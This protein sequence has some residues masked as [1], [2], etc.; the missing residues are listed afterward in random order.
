MS[1]IKFFLSEIR[2]KVFKNK[3]KFTYDELVNEL[4]HHSSGSIPSRAKL[5]QLFSDGDN[6]IDI[7]VKL[8]QNPCLAKYIG[9]S[10]FNKFEK[11]F[12]K[13]N[14]LKTNLNGTWVAYRLTHN[15]ELN[16]SIWKFEFN[17]KTNSLIV[18]K[19]SVDGEFEGEFNIDRY[20]QLSG[21]FVSPTKIVMV[22]STFLTSEDLEAIT[23]NVSYKKNNRIFY[24]HEVMYKQ[25]EKK[26]ELE[27]DVYK[28]IK[29][30]KLYKDKLDIGDYIAFD[31][32]TKLSG[33]SRPVVNE[34][35]NLYDHTLFIS[36]PVRSFNAAEEAEFNIIKNI[37]VQIK[38]K[39]LELFD[40]EEVHCEILEIEFNKSKKLVRNIYEESWNHLNSS[41]FISILPKEIDDR[42]SGVFFEIYYRIAKNLPCLVFLD[43]MVN[44][45]SVLK[46]YKKEKHPNVLFEE[47][48]LKEIPTIIEQNQERLFDFT[49]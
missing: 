49:L 9:F 10:S 21:C 19:N 45:P 48:E 32:L 13:T 1:A 43:P 8:N 23:M 47:V 41:H 20:Y 40:I 4:K 37:V 5:Q 44:L 36:C 11:Y 15:M 27:P 17:N 34:K 12:N 46:G 14:R 30:N 33:Q 26:N 38:D 7:A 24:F 35:G 6:D 25:I 3:S 39:V 28:K 2:N 22:Y 18:N 16:R 31:Y 29:F 42:N